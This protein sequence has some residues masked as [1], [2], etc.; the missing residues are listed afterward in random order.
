[1][2]YLLLF[3]NPFADDEYFGWFP[4]LAIVSR[5]AANGGA[6]ISDLLCSILLGVYPSN[7]TVRS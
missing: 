2:I 5:A 4:I 3:E 6:T 1:M 7:G